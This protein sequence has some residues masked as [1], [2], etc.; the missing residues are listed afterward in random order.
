MNDNQALALEIIKETY[1]S[2]IS[3][4]GEPALNEAGAIVVQFQDD[5]KVLEA[6]IT[7]TDIEIGLLNADDIEGDEG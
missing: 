3:A 4:I 7:D 5:M 1:T 6:L 2:D